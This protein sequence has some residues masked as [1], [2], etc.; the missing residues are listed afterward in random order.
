MPDMPVAIRNAVSE[1]TAEIQKLA[2]Q[3]NL[4]STK[5]VWLNVVGAIKTAGVR[6]LR[7]FVRILETKFSPRDTVPALAFIA[8]IP[9]KSLVDREGGILGSYA[10]HS[11]VHGP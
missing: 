4:S 5:R 7:I 6:I 11:I 1:K 10:G 8:C 2:D 3:L 9:M